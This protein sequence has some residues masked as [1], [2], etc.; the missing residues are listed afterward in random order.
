MIYV[1]HD[2]TQPER[3]GLPANPVIPPSYTYWKWLAK[4]TGLILGLLGIVAFFFHRIVYGP[5][6]IKPEPPIVETGPRDEVEAGRE[7]TP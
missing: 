2:I 3:Y 5:K 1:L 7:T 4:P 6:P